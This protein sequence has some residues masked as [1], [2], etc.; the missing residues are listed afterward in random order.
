MRFLLVALLAGCPKQ[1]G[2]FTGDSNGPDAG[3]DDGPD[4]AGIGLPCVYERDGE[5][6]TN[7]CGRGLRCLIFTGDGAFTSGMTLD[8]WEDQST[9]YLPDTDEGYCTLVSL[10]GEA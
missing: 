3:P 8:L 6:P 10:F 4:L 9:L 2:S 5:D 1:G 7:D